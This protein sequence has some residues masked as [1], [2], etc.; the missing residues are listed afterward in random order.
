MMH[1]CSVSEVRVMYVELHVCF[2]MIEH[3][4]DEFAEIKPESDQ[5][6]KRLSVKVFMRIK[7]FK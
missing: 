1:Q 7:R 3:V 6:S 5:I 2:P 4:M